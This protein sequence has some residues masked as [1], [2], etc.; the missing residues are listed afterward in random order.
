MTPT[1]DDIFDLGAE[2]SPQS[3]VPALDD[4]ILSLF[5]QENVPGTG[6][7][8]LGEDGEMRPV[9]P[10]DDYM[11]AVSSD[12]FSV[13]LAESV[14]ERVMDKISQDLLDAIDNDI[15]SRGPWTDRFQRGFEML[16][17]TE[18]EMDDGPFPGSC[19]SVMPVLSEAIVQ[20]WAR[21]LAELVPSDGPAKGQTKGKSSKANDARARRV[22]EYINHDVMFLDRSWYSDMSRMLFALPFTGSTFKKVYRDYE[23]GRNTSVFVQAED[24][25]CNYA[26]SD[27]E[28]A[29][30]YTHRIWRTRNE[31]LKCQVA[32]VYRRVELQAPSLEELSEEAKIRVEASDFESDTNAQGDIRHELYEVY[33]ELVIEGDERED[34]IARPYTITIDRS[35]G[36]VLSIYRAW[37]EQDP[38]ERRRSVFVKYDYLPGPGFYGL[39]LLHM[40]GGLQDAATGALRAILDGAATAS[41]QGG[42]MSSDA[43]MRDQNLVIEP[44]VWKKVDATAE[45]LSNA[46]FT[47]PFKEPSPV[48][49][50]IMGYIVQRA[51]KFAAT[52]EMMTGSENSKNMPVGST[53]AMIEQGGKVFSTIHRGLHKTLGDEL[54]M[55]FE[56]VQE[57]APPEGYPYDVEGAH[58]GILAEDFA[59][60]VSVV[61]VSDPNIF[62]QAQRIALNQA[63]YD[64][65]QQ[66]PDIIQRPAAVRRVLEGL[67][68]PDIEELLVQTAPP[69]PMGPVSEVQSLLRG[70]PVQAYPDQDHVAH[71]QHLAAFANNPQFGA[72]PQ[73]AQ[74]VGPALMALMGQH[75]AYAWAT[76]ARALGVPEDLMPP[77]MGD[78]RQQQMQEGMGGMMP[79]QQQIAPP[80]DPQAQMMMPQQPVPPPQDGSAPPEVIA[81]IAAQIA[82]QMAQAPGL[83]SPDAQAM[84]EKAQAETAKMQ[85]D[86]KKSEIDQQKSM[87]DISLKQAEGEHRQREFQ[88]KEVATQQDLALRAK[89]VSLKEIDIEM[90]RQEAIKKDEERAAKRMAEEQ[91]M[92]AEAEK[93][94]MNILREAQKAQQEEARHQQSMAIEEQRVQTERE[95]ARVK[96]AI[97]AAEAEDKKEQRK[98]EMEIKKTQAERQSAEAKKSAEASGSSEHL[99]AALSV[100]EGLSKSMS[101]PKRIVR[102][103]DGKAVGV[104]SYDPEGGES[105]PKSKG[106]KGK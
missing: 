1:P 71:I 52:T 3:G 14:D 36:K 63:V 70:E 53:L 82:P 44:G 2:N 86:I 62:S 41:L 64:L 4:D 58:E 34:G 65:A 7:Y 15:E 60:G 87:L 6:T 93:E 37:R 83:P 51:E 19:A 48:L 12:E 9:A 57:F 67:N 106:K 29:P 103:A 16:G 27:L 61:P 47:P 72:N 32:G 33:C 88:L 105:K 69:P 43:A 80:Q 89:D 28:S 54:R 94:R 46:F 73:V 91:K 20:F 76:H 13:N 74:Q 22:A 25:I 102:D 98:R 77:V 59:P 23:Q 96:A 11:P 104:E 45:Q 39:G 42:F 79:P 92:Q 101:A 100:I 85:A 21:A 97:M 35:S 90:K 30:R 10:E 26:F 95:L 56:L 81:Q 84:A 55:R 24:F 75:L 38:L 8:E 17:I 68:V 31:I 18:S 40:I 78:A 49:F 66:N 5:L 50:Q 99:T